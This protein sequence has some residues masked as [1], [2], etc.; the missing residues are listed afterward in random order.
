MASCSALYALLVLAAALAAALP[1]AAQ[2]PPPDPLQVGPWQGR[3]APAGPAACCAV[4]QPSLPSCN[5]KAVHALCHQLHPRTL[6]PCSGKRVGAHL[7][8]HGRH[9]HPQFRPP[10]CN[11]ATCEGCREYV[12]SLDNVTDAVAPANPCGDD[13]AYFPGGWVTSLPPP[14]RRL[15]RPFRRPTFPLPPLTPQCRLSGLPTASSGGAS[16]GCACPAA[17]VRQPSLLCVRADG[18]SLAPLQTTLEPAPIPS[19][20][21]RPPACLQPRSWL[22]AGRDAVAGPGPRRRQAQRHLEPRLWL[23]GLPRRRRGPAG[24][25]A[26]F[27]LPLMLPLPRLPPRPAAQPVPG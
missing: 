12:F 18:L 1:A 26:I 23:R 6:T 10:G 7:P 13:G 22:R 4:R 17:Q 21:P 14:A 2:P 19:R 20:N 27:H 3:L 25:A 9:L 11:P 16:P 8:F 15:P 24:G 5:Y